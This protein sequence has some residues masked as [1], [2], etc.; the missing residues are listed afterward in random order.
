V[1]PVHVSGHARQ[2]ELRTLLS[3]ARPEWFVPVH[4]EYRHLVNH[5]RLAQQMGIAE[6]H[7]LLCED[8]DVVEL[9]DDGLRRAERVPAGFLYVDGN[10]G[11]VEHG[12]L[13]DRRVLAEEGVVVA[14]ATVDLRAGEVVGA[15]AIITRGWVHA[16]EAEG[17]LGEASDAVRAA[18][19]K[20][21]ADG[22][23]DHE[24]L[25]RHARR[26]LGRFVGERTRRRPMIVPVV[27]TV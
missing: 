16:P 20:A 22:G 8:G 10:V 2:G 14:V 25:Q 17:L 24:S 21:L 23:A 11:D 9:T 27:V 4:G 5:V 19:E 18:L 6:E 3:V 15:P 26:A 7:A 1:A 13:R 12:V